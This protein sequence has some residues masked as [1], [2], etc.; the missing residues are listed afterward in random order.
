MAVPRARR[1]TAHGGVAGPNGRYGEP[2]DSSCRSNAKYL[3]CVEEPCAAS[4]V[5][6]SPGGVVLEWATKK[7]M[8]GAA[9]VEGGFTGDVQEV[10]VKC[11]VGR[12]PSQKSFYILVSQQDGERRRGGVV[13]LLFSALPPLPSQ[14][15]IEHISNDASRYA[16]LMS[17]FL[18][19]ARR[20]PQDIRTPTRT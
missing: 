9:A 16:I 8:E 1:R 5:E 20:D 19:E 18:G 4:G 17:L 3:H 13:P 7:D 10:R 12:F 6:G 2:W 11:R 14:A 15:R